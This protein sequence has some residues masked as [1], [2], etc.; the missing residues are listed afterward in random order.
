MDCGAERDFGAPTLGRVFDER[1]SA[2]R[3][4]GDS[5]PVVAMRLSTF[6]RFSSNSARFSFLIEV[7]TLCAEGSAGLPSGV[8]R[9][10]PRSVRGV[11]T[12]A[13][14]DMSSEA[15][16]PVTKRCASSIASPLQPSLRQLGAAQRSR[17]QGG[18]IGRRLSRRLRMCVRNGV[19]QFLG[20]AEGVLCG[21]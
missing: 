9:V 16:G 21:E 10:D 7:F 19:V 1:S 6:E 8:K 5:I 20:R 15:D 3:L 13:D 11:S 4:V 2:A 14:G 17:K 18:L 12:M